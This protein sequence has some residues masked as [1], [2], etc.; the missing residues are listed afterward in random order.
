[1]G[2]ACGKRY[3]SLNIVIGDNGHRPCEYLSCKQG[4]NI[5]SI[6][7]EVFHGTNGTLLLKT[8]LG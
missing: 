4:T 7:V 6:I 5:R 8:V 1:M 3:Y 2:R